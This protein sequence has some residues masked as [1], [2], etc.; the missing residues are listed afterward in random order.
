MSK[1]EIATLDGI[2]L[3]ISTENVKRIIPH[4]TRDEM[5]IRLN[6]LPAN[7]HGMMFQF[8]WRTGCRISEALGVTKEDIDFTND[9][10]TIKWL[11]R[12]KYHFRPIPLHN[13]LKQPLY[14]FTAH[15]NNP[16]K[17]FPITR[18]RAFQLCRKYGF[19][20]PH[21]IRHSFS[22]NFLRQSDRPMAII[23]LKELLG[24]KDIETTMKYLKVVP[25]N[26]KTALSK[27][28]FD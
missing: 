12:R 17:L 13:S 6:Q 15:L 19:D 23:E 24:H 2:K 22:I 16:D 27:I 10:I 1:Q 9:E 5:L 8:L 20:H 14:I 18:Q 25:Q 26:M 28:S 3:T 21:K 4:F 7:M 11:K